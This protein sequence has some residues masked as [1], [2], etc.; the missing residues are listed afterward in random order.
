MENLRPWE[1][2]FWSIIL[3][4]LTW[5]LGYKAEQNVFSDILPFSLAFFLIYWHIFK[6]VYH[7]K[8]VYFFLGLGIL[9]RF[10]LIFGVPN[11]SDDIYRFVW[12]GRLINNGINPFDHLPS[13]YIDSEVTVQG[14]DKALYNELNSPEYFTIYPPVCQLIFAFTTFV[15]PT[16]VWGNALLMKLLFVLFETGTI[17]LLVKL[18]AHFKLSIKNALLYALNPLIIIE[19]TGNLHFEAPMIFFLCLSIWLLVKKRWKTSAIAIAL[20]IASKLLPLIFLPLLIRRLGWKQS[21]YYFTVV[22]ITLVLLFAPMINGVFI[23]NFGDSLNLYFQKFEFNASIYYLA[24]YIGFQIKGYN[25]IQML[26]PILGLTA[27]LGI[28]GIAWREK[29]IQWKY[30][31]EAM[32]FSICCY[33]AVTTTVHPWYVSLPIVLCVFTS[34]R[35]PILWSGLIWLTYINYSYAVYTENLWVVGFE[36]V[37]VYLLFGYEFLNWERR[38]LLEGD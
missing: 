21:F 24:R 3:I 27:F 26:G 7:L 22:G 11:L 31:P 20:S 16:S 35:F 28:L 36:Y 4:V 18:L 19:L 33:L 12:D 14:L 15:F 1:K 2:Y 9:L 37:L 38:G 29:N 34:F 32:L 5:G 6:N 10:L 23:S 17:V 8:S 30:L 13:Y 25:L